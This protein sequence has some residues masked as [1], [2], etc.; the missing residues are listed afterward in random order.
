M[1]LELGTILIDK[2]GR[3]WKIVD[4]LFNHIW[5]IME[6]YGLDRNKPKVRYVPN[7]RLLTEYKVF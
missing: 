4:N 1:K 5:I 6:C 7:F 3:Q 2:K